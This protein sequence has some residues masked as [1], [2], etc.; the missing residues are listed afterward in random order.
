[1]RSAERQHL[2]GQAARPVRRRD[3]LVQAFAHPV[4][5]FEFGEGRAAEAADYGQLVVELVRDAAGQL[6]QRLH[7]LSM[8]ELAFRLDQFI[9]GCRKLRRAV[10][11][12]LFKRP[13]QRLDGLERLFRV[14]RGQAK[15]LFGL[16][17]L[18]HVFDPVAEQRR[19]DRLGQEV[20][21]PYVERALDRGGV[22]ERGHHEDRNVL[23]GG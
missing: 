14:P 11:D 3:D 4:V 7:L 9:A 13:A 17:G 23:G 6:A 5:V 8:A 16:A 18:H 22:V 12:L 19:I 1:V 10:L 2:A 21:R 20:R 15:L